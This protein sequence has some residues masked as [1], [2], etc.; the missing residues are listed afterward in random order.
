MKRWLLSISGSTTLLMAAHSPLF[1]RLHY[2]EDV[3]RSTRILSSKNPVDDTGDC[4]SLLLLFV[5]I[6]AHCRFMAH[7]DK[8]TLTYSIV[9]YYTFVTFD[10][11]G[12]CSK[13]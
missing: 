5:L 10:N 6:F 3:L 8:R 2:C 1:G 13:A 12:R 11:V 7:P 4:E 9:R